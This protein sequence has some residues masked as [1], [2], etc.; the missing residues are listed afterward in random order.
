MYVAFFLPKV[1]KMGKLTSEASQSW[2]ERIQNENIVEEGHRAH[3]RS[4]PALGNALFM[5]LFFKLEYNCLT[6]LC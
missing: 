1:Q 4:W 2:G 3:E 6:M 5:M